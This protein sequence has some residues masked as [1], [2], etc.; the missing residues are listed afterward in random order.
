MEKKMIIKDET[1]LSCFKTN[2]YN[3]LTIEERKKLA[4]DFINAI[5]LERNIS[6]LEIN[7]S[8][9]GFGFNP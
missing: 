6:P 3:R 5:V 1:L 2:N 8:G 9:D 4:K 7:F